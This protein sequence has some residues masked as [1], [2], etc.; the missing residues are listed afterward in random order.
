MTSH[1]FFASRRLRAATL[2]VVA[3]AALALTGC[4]S[5]GEPNNGGTT[6][7]SATESETPSATPIPT[8][9]GDMSRALNVTA[10]TLPGT[11]SANTKA[12]LESFTRYY[13][14]LLEYGYISGDVSKLE[15]V[16]AP[17]CSTCTGPIGDIENAYSNGGW[18]VG[19]ELEAT[20]VSTSFLPSASGSFF[21]NLSIKQGRTVYYSG[22]GLLRK[23]VP[24]P[25]QEAPMQL[26]A[27]FVSGAWQVEDFAPPK[28]LQ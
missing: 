4:N 14:E 5:G 1:N 25:L 16:I 2:A 19:G 23:D 9:A 26:T 10:P 15:G 21:V 24:A 13:V 7:P 3:A 6:S 11:A 28:G 8:P 20:A 22:P 12:G 27:G 18:V 17:S